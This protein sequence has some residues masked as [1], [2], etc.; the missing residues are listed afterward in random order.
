MKPD[1]TKLGL[2]RQDGFTLAELLAYMSIV[3][4]AI[5]VFTSFMVDVSKS[6][7]RM[8]VRQEVQQ[9]AR[10]LTTKI[11]NE[12]R[13]AAAVDAVQSSFNVDDGKI[14]VV[15]ASGP[16]VSFARDSA[17]DSVLFDDGSGAIP[18]SNDKVRVT[19]LRF[20]QTARGIAVD[21]TVEQGN[22]AAP[23]QLQNALVLS[24]TVVP[25]Q[26]LY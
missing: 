15:T 18:V 20:E 17:T 10:L 2:R 13:T 9:N 8:K 3:V 23:A 5:V 1:T 25:R 24:S 14:S 21:L 7:A 12:I 19:K 11:T 26:F 4:V 16:T 6:A 22:A